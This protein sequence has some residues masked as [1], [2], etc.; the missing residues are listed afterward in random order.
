METIS[1]A[2]DR[3]EGQE[4]CEE[5][6]HGQ[7]L[8]AVLA[9]NGVFCKVS[10]TWFIIIINKDTIAYITYPKFNDAI[11]HQFAER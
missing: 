7:G 8:T 3:P 6:V 2:S 1:K 5:A 4:Q 11:V 9:S 10:D